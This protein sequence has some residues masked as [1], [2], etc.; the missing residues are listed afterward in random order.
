MSY[1]WVVHPLIQSTAGQTEVRNMMVV[2]VLNMYRFLFF[3]LLPLFHK[4]YFLQEA[5]FTISGIPC[6]EGLGDSHMLRRP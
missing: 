6:W 3:F 2:S 1:L 5:L 4:E